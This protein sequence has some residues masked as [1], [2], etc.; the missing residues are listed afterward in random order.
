MG[1]ILGTYG[2]I[3][4]ENRIIEKSG[5]IRRESSESSRKNKGSRLDTARR[6][7]MIQIVGCVLSCSFSFLHQGVLFWWLSILILQADHP[8]VKK[9]YVIY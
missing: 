4:G 6:K 8:G 2:R 3:L 9:R 1:G 5:N 7:I